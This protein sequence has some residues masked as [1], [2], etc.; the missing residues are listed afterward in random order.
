MMKFCHVFFKSKVFS[1]VFCIGIL[2][3]CTLHI[4]IIYVHLLCY[5]IIARVMWESGT[6]SLDTDRSR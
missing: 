2:Y 5:N 3:Y 4:E 6:E 1:S